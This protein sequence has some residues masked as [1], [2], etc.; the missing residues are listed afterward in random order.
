[1]RFRQL[2]YDDYGKLKDKGPFKDQIPDPRTS[3]VVVAEDDG[4]IV[5]CA[6]NAVHIEPLWIAPEHRQKASVARGL[7]RE[8]KMLLGDNR[9]QSAFALIADVDA[10]VVLPMAFK[11]GF[12]RVPASVLFIGFDEE[13]A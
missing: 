12:Q 3:S 2:G 7:W 10:G 11:M 9:V 5:W 4:E 8:L 6:F 13:E 1:M